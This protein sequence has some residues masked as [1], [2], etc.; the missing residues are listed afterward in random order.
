MNHWK[1]WILKVQPVV[2]QWLQNNILEMNVGLVIKIKGLEQDAKLCPWATGD[3]NL[4]ALAA[5]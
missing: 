5:S 4:L 1:E 3:K 2:L